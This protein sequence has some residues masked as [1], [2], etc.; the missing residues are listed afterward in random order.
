MPWLKSFAW[1]QG[2]VIVALVFLV[3]RGSEPLPVAAGRAAVVAGTP[4]AAP[5]TG[6]NAP[7]QP[8]PPA[9]P[10][11]APAEP[12]PPVKG[13]EGT[14]LFG[15][16]VDEAGQP[17]RDCHLTFTREGETSQ[18]ARCYTQSHASYAVPGLQPG[19]VQIATRVTGFREL[20]ETVEIPADTPRL[21]HD[22]TLQQAWN[23]L[24]KI[25]TPEGRPIHEALLELAKERPGLA[26]LEV[27]AI[28]TPYQP[29]G[30]FPP[31]ELRE[32]PYGVGRWRSATG[33]GRMDGPK[34]GKE[35]AGTME[36]DQRRALWISA[37]L[38]HRLLASVAIEPGQAEVSL[39]VAIDRLQ[40]ELG[41]IRLRV[42]DGATGAPVTTAMVGFSDVQSGGGGAKPDA[43]GVVEV[44]DLRPGLLRMEIR[45]QGGSAPPAQVLLE[46]GQ[47]LDLG[48]VPVLAQRE[49]KGRL[50]GQDQDAKEHDSKVMRMS[51]QAYPLDVTLSPKL[52]AQSHR[53]QV[54]ED[55]TFRF[56]MPDGRYFLRASGGGGATAVID[57]KTL[58][59]EPIVLRLQKEGAFRLDAKTGGELL[60]LTITGSDGRRVFRRWLPDGVKYP[61]MA[62]PGDYRVEL[63]DRAGKVTMR[64]VRLGVEGM[65]LRVP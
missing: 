32:A 57:T 55:G 17:V 47:T 24:V 36:L 29:A 4:A 56:W 12:A 40:Q 35:Y 51:V 37:V 61:I 30:D 21:R 28:A 15:C 41:T 39:T 22:V 64:Q 13:P 38:R 58:G 10:D 25:V 63:Q 7:A 53:A 3:L 18:L 62:L 23:L 6:A 48:D 45:T 20:R 11:A 9:V 33:F 65:D 34:I 27:A 14:I 52:E 42:V 19:K 49:I 16:V 31:T 44:R 5:L 54:E 1:L 60:Q 59:N 8:A 26:R 2:A 46:P 43:Q 50:E